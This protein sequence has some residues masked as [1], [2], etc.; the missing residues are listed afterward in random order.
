MQNNESHPQRIIPEEDQQ[1]ALRF[2]DDND[3]AYEA[4][5]D[6]IG[7]E[8]NDFGDEGD[9][10]ED[11]DID[12][13]FNE[14][15]GDAATGKERQTRRPLPERLCRAFQD[16]VAACG[17]D[18]RDEKGLP[19]LYYRDRTFWYPQPS[20]FFLL[21]NAPSPQKL[22][23]PQFFVWD[24]EPLCAGGICCPR[25]GVRLRRHGNVPRPRRCVDLDAPFWIVGY[26]Y[27]C[28]AC[29]NPESGKRTV[30]F[31]SWDPRILAVLPRDLALEFPARLSHRSGLSKTVFAL[32]RTCFQ[33]GMSAK[34]SSD[35]LRVLHLLRYDKLHRQ[36]LHSLAGRRQF[37]SWTGHK[38]K[39]FLPFD[40][41][42]PDGYQGFVP[43]AQWLRNMYDCYIG[44]H[45]MD[46]NQHTALLSAEV[47]GIDHSHKVCNESV[48]LSHY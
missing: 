33:D 43:S 21:H 16:V 17:P 40:D 10:D 23:N 25:C 47:C 20:T 24:P 2:D 28:P 22:F 3:D 26:R 9:R 8:D 39:S 41:G 34:Q 48:L 5:G 35:L 11:E 4:D 27:Y 13:E 29:V 31:R 36:Y 44:D 19:P 38:Y 18:S 7:Q 37:N 32:T 46:F 45:E 15:I 1:Q 42:T 6:G 14:N 12:G 30:T